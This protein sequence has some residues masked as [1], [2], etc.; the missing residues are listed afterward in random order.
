MFFVDNFEYSFCKYTIKVKKNK[1]P[2]N[3]HTKH[4]KHMHIKLEISRENKTLNNEL[5]Q[6]QICICTLVLFFKSTSFVTT[7]LG[8]KGGNFS[9]VLPR[10]WGEGVLQDDLV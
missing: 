9:V 6:K 3:K 5:L 2:S 7:S 1:A 4:H 10:W 8:N